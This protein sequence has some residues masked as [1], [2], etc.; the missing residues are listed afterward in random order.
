MPYERQVIWSAESSRKAVLIKEFL[1]EEWSE[2][3]VFKFFEKLKKFE[4][5]V[6]QFPLLYP[7]SLK[8]PELRKAVI[9]KNQS[10]IYEVDD[11]SIRI[12]TILDHRQQET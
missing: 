5:R 1:L 8:H 2:K 3:E 12:I 7:A 11:D 4:H 9:S 6:Q 10:V